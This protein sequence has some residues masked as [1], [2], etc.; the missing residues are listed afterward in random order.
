M[1]NGEMIRS[2][3]DYNE[4]ANRRLF[5]CVDRLEAR[6]PASMRERFGAS[7]DSIAGTYAHILQG[8]YVY[9]MRWLGIDRPALPTGDDAIADL[10]RRWQEHTALIHRWLAQAPDG[11]LDQP[12]PT[13]RYDHEFAQPA[14]QQLLALINHGSHHRSELADMLTRAGEPPP[15]FD[16][17]DFYAERAGATITP[18]AH[19]VPRRRR[20]C[21]CEEATP[22]EAIPQASTAPRTWSDAPSS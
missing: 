12:I 10:R 5:D 6:A 21:R 8:E 9:S 1:T 22:D 15:P 11:A 4:W 14:W 19:E 13:R 18:A 20:L 3:F 7:F 16:V 17:A 2:F